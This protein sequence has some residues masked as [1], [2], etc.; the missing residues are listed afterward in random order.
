MCLY[1]QVHLRVHMPVRTTTSL[2]VHSLCENV[3]VYVRALICGLLMYWL[4]L[5]YNCVLF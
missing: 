1:L 2:S 3:P 5:T 4:V